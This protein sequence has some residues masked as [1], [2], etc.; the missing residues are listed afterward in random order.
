VFALLGPNG[1]GRPHIEILEG[2][3]NRPSGQVETLGVDP[4]DTKDPAVAPVPY[5]V[6][7]QE[8]AVEPS[9]L[10][11]RSVRNAGTT[12]RPVRSRRSIDLVGPDEKADAGS[13]PFGRSATRLVP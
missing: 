8:L 10:F 13:R 11:A 7:L 9:T 3:R 1:A 2:F 5:R 4:S 12:H 6:V